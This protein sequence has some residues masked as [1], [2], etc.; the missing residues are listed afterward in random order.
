M[1]KASDTTDV[2]DPFDLSRFTSAQERIYDSVLAELRR[3]Q[4]K[5]I[6]SYFESR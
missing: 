2:D 4:K 1:I 6:E 5:I 3:G